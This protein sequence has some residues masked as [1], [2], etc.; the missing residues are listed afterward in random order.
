MGVAAFSP[1]PIRVGIRVAC[2]E[3]CQEKKGD[4]LGGLLGVLSLCSFKESGLPAL[5]PFLIQT[6]PRRAQGEGCSEPKSLSSHVQPW[7]A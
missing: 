1:L 2:W 4:C 5:L 3:E 6:L 7:D